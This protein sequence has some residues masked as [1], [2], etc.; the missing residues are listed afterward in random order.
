MFNWLRKLFASEKPVKQVESTRPVAYTTQTTAPVVL[1]SQ[2]V[3]TE[4][5]YVDG[6]TQEPVAEPKPKKKRYYKPKQKKTGDAPTQ[7]A[8]PK[9]AKPRNNKDSK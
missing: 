8:K 3:A 2:A 1:D 4:T 9:S 5:P 7:E 6:V